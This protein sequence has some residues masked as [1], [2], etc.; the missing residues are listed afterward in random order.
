MIYLNRH[1]KGLGGA[2]KQ[3]LESKENFAV[4]N[5]LQFLLAMERWGFGLVQGEQENTEDI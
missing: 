5:I 2:G 4:H 1:Q 3:S